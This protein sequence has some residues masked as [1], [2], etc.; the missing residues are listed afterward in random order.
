MGHLHRLP[1]GGAVLLAYAGYR[2][3]AS[4]V[5]EPLVDADAARHLGADL[6]A[7]GH[8]VALAAPA[9]V[10]GATLVTL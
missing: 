1:A 8:D 6:R 4:H 10:S 9:P 7:M 5:P 3:R 2:I